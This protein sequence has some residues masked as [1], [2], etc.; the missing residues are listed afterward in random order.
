MSE[1]DAKQVVPKE[2]LPEYKRHARLKG[3][4]IGINEAAKEYGIPQRTISRWVQRGYIRRIGREGLKVLIDKQDVAYCAEIYR[5]RGG[6][7]GRWLF[8]PDG[9]PHTPKAIVG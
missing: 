9:T 6:T 8:N 5:Q 1:Q 3:M 2:R 4:T 7:A